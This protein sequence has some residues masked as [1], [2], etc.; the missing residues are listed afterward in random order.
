[1]GDE[2]EIGKV[3]RKKKKSHKERQSE[4]KK[5]K[6]VTT[7]TA[8]QAA[9]GRLGNGSPICWGRDP[10]RRERWKYKNKNISKGKK[11]KRV[12][13]REEKQEEKSPGDDSRKPCKSILERP[14]VF[15]KR[16][17]PKKKGKSQLDDLTDSEWKNLSEVRKRGEKGDQRRER[18]AGFQCRGETRLKLKKQQTKKKTKRG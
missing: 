1:M 13:L 6:K 16:I 10:I 18:S 8:W 3:M 2:N 5:S 14:G 9:A 7:K 4:G 12:C 15:S 11:S 17:R